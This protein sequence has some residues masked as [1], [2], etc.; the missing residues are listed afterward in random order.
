MVKKQNPEG[1]M[2]LSGHLKELRNRLFWSAI[3]LLAGSIAG[4]F[5]F[6]DV[7]AELQR[8]I[9]ALAEQPGSNATINFPT[10]VSAF[11]VRLQVSIFLG[12]LMSSPVW[13]FNI[14]SFIT[15]G[16]KKKERKYTIWFVVVAVPLFLAGTALAWSSLPTFV[17]VLVGFTPEGSANVINAS[18]YILF[19]IRILLVFGIAFVLP[20]VLVLLNFAGVITAQNILKSWRMAIFVS[21]VVGAIAT[22]AA[23]PTAMVLL[24]V[25][26]LI[27]Y[28]VAAGVATMHDKRLARKSESIDIELETPQANN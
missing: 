3:F 12:V 4:W 22:P 17:Q 28:F 1:K 9:V 10:V 21:A 27:L 6:D 11:D 26:L 7:F 20:V 24:M 8:P 14:W 19:T 18:E 23:E 16:L 5:M 13:L 15:P 2:S 25:P